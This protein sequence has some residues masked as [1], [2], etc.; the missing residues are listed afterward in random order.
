M[1]NLNAVN[2][3]YVLL[4]HDKYKSLAFKN[5]T[6][7]QW[8]KSSTMTIQMDAMEID[9]VH[10]SSAQSAFLTQNTM[11]LAIL[12]L[13]GVKSRNMSSRLSRCLQ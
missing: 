8:I 6:F 4:N 11:H 2:P 7:S 9:R 5:F 13:S 12:I 1:K 10:T 3:L